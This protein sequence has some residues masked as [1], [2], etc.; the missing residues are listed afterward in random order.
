MLLI[1]GE[2]RAFSLPHN[3]NQNVFIYPVLVRMT[4]KTKLAVN[5]HFIT[6]AFSYL[7]VVEK[8]SQLLHCLNN[9]KYNVKGDSL[10]QNL[11]YDVFLL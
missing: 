1:V 11:F 10:M 2:K 8:H 3:V 4:T 7:T 9:N 5:N 6:Y